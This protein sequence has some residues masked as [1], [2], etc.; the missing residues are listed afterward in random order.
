MKRES[1]AISIVL[2]HGLIEGRKSMKRLVDGVL[3]GLQL[4]QDK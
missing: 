2:M 4:L 1:A 3:S